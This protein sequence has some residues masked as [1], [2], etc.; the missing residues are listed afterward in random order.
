MPKN[1][2]VTIYLSFLEMQA[3]MN[4]NHE[5][6]PCFM[7]SISCTLNWHYKHNKG[8]GAL[9]IIM[10][11]MKRKVRERQEDQEKQRKEEAFH[12]AINRGRELLKPLS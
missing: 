2:K 1:Y 5:N 3:L 10:D 8:V 11:A 7:I 9:Y 4:L 6:V 12:N